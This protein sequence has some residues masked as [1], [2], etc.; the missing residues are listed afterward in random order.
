MNIHIVKWD[1]VQARAFV[2]I[3]SMTHVRDM[4]PQDMIA[5]VAWIDAHDLTPIPWLE[6]YACVHNDGTDDGRQQEYILSEKQS[7]LFLLRFK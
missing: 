7:A 1:S 5:M 2:D 3:D 4:S 6:S